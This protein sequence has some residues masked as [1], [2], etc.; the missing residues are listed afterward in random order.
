MSTIYKS[1]L[2]FLAVFI[3]ITATLYTQFSYAAEQN[4]PKRGPER[5]IEKLDLSDNQTEQFRSIMD[6]QHQKRMD[7]HEQYKE[8]REEEHEA[9]EVLHQETIGRLTPVLTAEQLESFEETIK[10]HRPKRRPEPK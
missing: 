5:M 6:E 2:G 10:K 1:T 4:R 7:V 3:L 8:S 9:M